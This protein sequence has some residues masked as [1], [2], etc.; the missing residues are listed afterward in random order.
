MAVLPALQRRGIGSEL[1]RAGLREC[2]AQGAAL[3]FVL[4]HP[5]YYPRF[6]FVPAAPLGMHYQSETFDPAFF[7]LELEP[8]NLAGLQGWVRYHPAFDQP[9][10][11][12][13][14]ARPEHIPALPDIELAAAALLEGHAPASILNESTSEEEFREAQAEG[15]LWVALADD[16]PVGFA[17]VTILGTGQPHL[18]EIDVHPRHGR[19]GLGRALVTTVCEWAASSGYAEVTLTTFRDITWNM[20]FY[21]RLGF[22]VVPHEDL[23]PEL[24]GIVREETARGLD[25]GRRVVMRY[26]TGA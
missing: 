8:K 7:V 24:A 4:G 6:G 9:A 20:P 3:V 10:N 19:R 13:V 25:P 1:V 14:T 22:E 17:L 15:R 12:I 11:T 21:A 2:A 26:E 5:E 16:T 23:E 18:E